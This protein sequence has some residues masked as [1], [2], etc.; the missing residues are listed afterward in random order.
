M[1][2]LVWVFFL[3][4]LLLTSGCNSG[5]KDP[6]NDNKAKPETE[7]AITDINNPRSL[8]DTT[9]SEFIKGINNNDPN[10]LISCIDPKQKDYYPTERTKAAVS[11]FKTLL[12]TQLQSKFISSRIENGENIFTYNITGG[13]KEKKIDIIVSEK[14]S[15]IRDLFLTY[16]YFAG[17]Q[18]DNFIAA[19]KDNNKSMLVSA[20]SEDDKYFPESEVEKVFINY[21]KIF[22]LHTL[23]YQLVDFGEDYF[24][25]SITGTKN[26]KPAEHRLKIIC[27]DGITGI[28]DELVP[29]F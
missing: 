25:Y 19:L 12:G 1:K 23:N 7:T 21:Q 5:K 10:L 22:D 26:G 27:G 3:S 24:V 20:L 15:F 17:L 2:K 28:R 13:K 14:Q 18:L 9:L 6:G 8:A 16:S 11:A 29:S 4:V